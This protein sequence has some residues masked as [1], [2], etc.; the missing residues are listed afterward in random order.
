MTQVHHLF[1]GATYGPERLKVLGR[2]FDRAWQSIA[3]D[4]GDAPAEVD[5][6]R[7]ALAKVILS[8]PSSDID[9]AERIKDAAL[10]VMAPVMGLARQ[11]ERIVSRHI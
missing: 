9:N 6:A 2:A 4:F 7:T 11:I 10:E 5:A 3:G 8:L 1:A